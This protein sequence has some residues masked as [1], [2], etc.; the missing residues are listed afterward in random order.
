MSEEAS[1]AAL[2]TLAMSVVIPTFRRELV[3][4]ETVDYLLK[5]QPRPAEILV[6]DQTTVHEPDTHSAL[7]ELERAKMIGWIRL[8]RPSI[9]HAMNVGLQRASHNIVLFVDDDIIPGP[10][11]V[12]AHARAHETQDCSI[13]AG[14]VLQPG[15][16]PVNDEPSGLGFKFCSSRRQHIS[17]F[18]GCN[19]SVKHKVALELGGFDENFVHVAYRFEAEF[20]ARALAAGEKIWFEPEANVRHLK[21]GSGGTRSYGDHLKTIKPS[22]TVGAYYCLLRAKETP[23][24]LLKIVGRPIRAIRTKHHLSHPWWIPATLIAEAAGFF[25]AVGLVLRGPRLLGAKGKELGAKG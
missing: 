1:L 17:E 13:V 6:V 10:D 3:L 16:E 12:S 21:T 14:Q 15:E 5:L 9:T 25:W 18:I 19:F 11:L 8:S 4:I 7:V 20:A 2:P 22:H 23:K 24:R